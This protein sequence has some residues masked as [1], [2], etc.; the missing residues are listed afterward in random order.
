MTAGEQLALDLEPLAHP[1]H[2]PEATIQE[3][4][5]AFHAANPWVYGAFERLTADWVTHGR[6]RIGIGMLTEVLRW[7][8]N[9]TTV[10]DPFKINNDYRS[11]YVR[12]LI[13]HH[14]EWADVFETRALKAA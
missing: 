10:G 5:E 11:R 13:D 8:Y 12:L 6:S 3:R 14:P 4:F 9:R 1:L 7:Q 2:D